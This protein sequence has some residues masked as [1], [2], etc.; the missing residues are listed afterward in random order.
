VE[1][2]SGNADVEVS[3]GSLRLGRLEGERHRLHSSSGS[4][5][6]EVLGG[7]VDVSSR[8]GGVALGVEILSGDLAFDI[9]SGSLELRLPREPGFY[10]DAES[11]SGR[12]TIHSREGDFS[13]RD[14]SSI[15]RPIG[16]NPERTIYARV[17]SGN[18]TINRD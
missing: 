7:E 16:E 13:T 15:L 1:R 11:S 2:I 9:R 14:R 5:E 6:V 10:L 3:S 8:S 4:I 18:I 17:Q 12:V